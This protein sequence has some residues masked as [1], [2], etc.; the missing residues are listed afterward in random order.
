MEQKEEDMYLGGDPKEKKY[1]LQQLSNVVKGF[2]IEVIAGNPKAYKL[3]KD[4]MDKYETVEERDEFLDRVLTIVCSD[5]RAINKF[6]KEYNDR[7]E[8]I[9]SPIVA[10][11][12]RCALGLKVPGLVTNC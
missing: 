3:V 7:Y 4:A 9:H 8:D 2:A 10:V 11:E 5:F 1:S 12:V 6:A